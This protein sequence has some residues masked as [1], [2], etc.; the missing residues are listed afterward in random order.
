[1]AEEKGEPDD[2]QQPAADE[3]RRCKNALNWLHAP[4]FQ[5]TPRRLLVSK[6]YLSPSRG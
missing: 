5:Q 1:M 6:P 4:F 2:Y 3:Y